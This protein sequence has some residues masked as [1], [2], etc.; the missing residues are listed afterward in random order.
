[1]KNTILII[2][3]ILFSSNF[4][5][6]QSINWQ[7]IQ[8]N[9]KNI[10]YL[11]LG[12]DF[13]VT[14]QLGY[15]YQLNASK[16]ILLTTDLSMPMGSD[17]M[18]DFKFRIGGQM[19]VFEKNNFSLS[20]KL[21]FSAK[22]HETNLVRQ[23]GLGSELSLTAG[24]YKSKWH[25]AA[26]MGFDNFIA[27]HLKHSDDIVSNYSEIQNGWFGNSGGQFFYGIQGS[28]TVGKRMEINLRLGAINAQGNHENALLPVYFQLGLVYK[29]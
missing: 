23:F 17:F 19:E 22:R 18:D 15:G 27:T 16:P 12:Y 7:S 11:N 13:G 14:T 10:A 29:L 6:S 25:V 20:A 2:L 8:E 5:F 21:L 9:Q 24:Y 1:M 3:S 4:A 26:E 28:K